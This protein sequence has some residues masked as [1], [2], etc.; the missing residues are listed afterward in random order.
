M[1]KRIVSLLF[2]ALFMALCLIPSAGT[3]VFGPSAA[4]ANEVLSPKPALTDRDGRFN[5]NV[6]ADAAAWLGDHFWL[7]QELVTGW[8]KLNAALFRTSA[9]EDVILGREGWLYFA[10]TLGD[11]TASETMTERELWC[12]ARTLYLLQEHVRS[13]GGEFVFTV[14]PNKNSLYPGAMPELPKSDAAANAEALPALLSEMGVNYLDLFS[15]FREQEEI[16]YFPTDSHWNGKGAAL[17][18]DGLLSA[19]GREGGYFASEFRPGQHKGDLY[20]MLY[21]AGKAADPDWVYAP[22]FT[23]E[24]GGSNP[25]A[26]TIR[27]Q[28]AAGAGSLVMYR[29]SFGRNLYPYLAERFENA[30]FSRKTDYGA[31]E[32]AEGDTVI[33]ELV[34]RNLSYL[35]LYSPSVPGAVRSAGLVSGAAAAGSLPLSASEEGNLLSLEG[36]F[37]LLRPDSDSPVYVMCAGTLFE[38]VP[39]PEG[40]RLCLDK[41]TDLADVTVFFTAEGNLTALEGVIEYK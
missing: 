13:L 3:A 40:F 20:E 38:A 39:R 28:S 7:R 17:A 30:V 35:N 33:V 36:E 32:P 41:D 24:G 11:Y 6:L 21:P 34:E 12:A 10:P 25:D 23:F 31:V 4:G 16:L 1:K 37:G 19:L 22:G 26:I 27:T 18:A 9:A 15:L 8:A 5:S 14:A 2:A 29:D